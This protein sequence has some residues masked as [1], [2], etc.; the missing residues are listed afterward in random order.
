MVAEGKPSSGLS[1][2]K[3]EENAMKSHYV[4]CH[5]LSAEI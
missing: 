4:V 1:I 5:N 3:P 2:T